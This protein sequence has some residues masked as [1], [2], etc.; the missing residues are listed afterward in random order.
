MNIE[1]FKKQAKIWERKFWISTIVT[2]TIIITT[3]FLLKKDM[4]WKDPVEWVILFAITLVGVVGS[5]ASTYSYFFAIKI[6]YDGIL[7]SQQSELVIN[8]LDA[9]LSQTAVINEETN[10]LTKSIADST[11]KTIIGLE[12]LLCATELFL[13]ESE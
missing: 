2:C 6:A 10:K 9:L 13:Q 8:R 11:Q 5:F 4:N 12:Q 1:Q 3:Y 7:N